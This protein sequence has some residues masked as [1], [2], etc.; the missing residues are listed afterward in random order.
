MSE[1]RENIKQWVLL[2]NDLT[3]MRNKSREMREEKNNLT[4][5]LYAHAEQNNLDTATIQISDGILKFQ[6]FKQKS[7]LTFRF[8]E[9]CLNDCLGD[10]EQV[11]SIIKYIKTKREEKISYIVKRTYN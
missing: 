9:E 5:C 1:F 4:D 7:P 2:D 3:A 8:L 11:K 10:D 6:Q